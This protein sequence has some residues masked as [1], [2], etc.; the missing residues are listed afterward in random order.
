MSTVYSLSIVNNSDQTGD[1]CLY[2]IDPNVKDPYVMPLAWYSKRANPSTKLNYQWTLDY[3]FVWANTGILTPGV[4]FFP[5]QIVNG[6]LT[7]DNMITFT[8]EN[9]S[10][11]FKDLTTNKS[12]E[13][14]L[15]IECDDTISRQQTSIGIGMSGAATFA[16]QAEPNMGFSFSPQIQY[17]LTFGYYQQGEV[18]N[19]DQISHFVTIDFPPNVYSMTAT[20]NADNTWTVQP[21]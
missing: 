17:R 20:L 16:R 5:S 4:V 8:N 2:Q 1:F 12:F 14:L 6:G 15:H 13:G 3:S 18:L 9:G 21:S 7:Q 10:Y 19:T 11:Q